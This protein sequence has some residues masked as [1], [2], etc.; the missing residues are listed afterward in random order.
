MLEVQ[1]LKTFSCRCDDILLSEPADEVRV[2]ME[3]IGIKPLIENNTS[4][5]KAMIRIILIVLVAEFVSCNAFSAKPV[6]LAFDVVASV[7]GSFTCNFV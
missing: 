3:L 2:L 6:I 5:R 4:S 1:L 7:F